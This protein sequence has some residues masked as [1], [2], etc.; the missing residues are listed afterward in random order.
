MYTF[1]N[2]FCKNLA[3]GQF[4]QKIVSEAFVPNFISYK[5]V[6]Y[7][8]VVKQTVIQILALL[9]KIVLTVYSIYARCLIF[10]KNLTN[11]ECYISIL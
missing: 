7:S 8:F 5:T 10:G 11:G 6:K 4:Y 9:S 2:F 1:V 3:N